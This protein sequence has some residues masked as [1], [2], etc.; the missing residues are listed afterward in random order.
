MAK[1][2]NIGMIGYGFMG[3]AHTN[4]YRQVSHFFDLPYQPVLK[5]ACC[6]RCGQGQGVCRQVGLRV[7]RDRLAKAART[8][9]HRCRRYLHAEQ[10]SRRDRDRGGRGRQDDPVREAA[11]HERA[12]RAEDGRGGREGEGAEHRLVQ[13][14]PRA[15]RARWPSSSS[16][17]AGSAR[18]ST[19]APSSCKTG[20]SRPICR[21]AAPGCGGSTR[22]RPGPA[23]PAICSPTA[24]T[25]ALWLNG[26][27]KNLSAHDRDVHQGTQAHAHRQ[28]RE[29]RHRRRLLV[30]VPLRERL[31]RPVR[32][33]PLR[34]RPQGAV[35][36][37]DQRREGVA[38][39]G[40]CTI[41]IGSSTSITRT[42]ARSAAGSRSTSPTAI[43]PTWANGGF[44]ACRSATST[45]SR[46]RSP[47][48]WT[49]SPPASRQARLPRCLGDATGARR[50]SGFG[51]GGNLG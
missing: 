49:A 42:R 32:V 45:A 40:T 29:G 1:P 9:G 14:P 28:G 51:K 30:H 3:R 38:R 2:L 16:T 31:A 21:R 20:P 5:A 34:P 36:V 35:H 22:R 23:S 39:S 17:R 47:T 11:R 13:L 50:D 19:I 18:S 6:P 7:D 24:S 37:R 43:I 25:T 4:A 12:R 10:L 8:Q 41:C 48:S 15:G 27:I 46:I 33:D 26:G 44:R